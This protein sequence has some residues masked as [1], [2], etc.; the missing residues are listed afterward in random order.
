MKTETMLVHEAMATLKILDNRI[1]NTMNDNFFF[2]N[3]HSNT[4]INGQPIE[5]VVQH[6]A[7]THQ[8]IMDM[9]KRRQA[10]KNALSLS[11]AQT[12]VTIGG[13]E[14]TVAEAIEMKRSGIQL[15]RSY[16]NIL[17]RQLTNAQQNCYQQNSRL[18]TEA[19]A[20]IQQL[21]GGKEKMDS[22]DALNMRK[23]YLESRTYEI[24]SAANMDKQIPIL[25]TEI[26]AFE[27]EVDAKL[28]ISNATTTIEITY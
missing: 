20:Y 19:D 28:S 22:E 26:D 18:D 4:K 25:L 13:V 17:Q 9:I 27:S 10:I 23:A 2:A 3:K 24:V 6:I 14:Y 16:M 8:S 5:V 7:D 15:K 12:K 21:Y 11:N 1:M